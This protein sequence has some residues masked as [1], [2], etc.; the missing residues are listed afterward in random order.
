MRRRTGLSITLLSAILVMGIFVM[1]E[2]GSTSPASESVKPFAHQGGRN[3]PYQKVFLKKGDVITQGRKNGDTCFF[4]EPFGVGT[5]IVGS[6]PDLKIG[7][8]IEEDCRVRVDKVEPSRGIDNPPPA[9]GRIV[10]PTELNSLEGGR[11]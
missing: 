3:K 9:G 2:V 11:S 10:V 5:E 1:S 4:E 6:A 8:V 7:W